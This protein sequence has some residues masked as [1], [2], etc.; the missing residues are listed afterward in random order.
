MSN[1]FTT[2][3]G[4]L[5]AV[6]FC[7]FSFTANA[8]TTLLTEDFETWPLTTQGWSFESLDPATGAS[9]TPLPGS[10]NFNATVS[11]TGT[12]SAHHDWWGGT[13]PFPAYNDWMVSPAIDLT[14]AVNP[15]MSFWQFTYW[16]ANYAFY[17][18][19]SVSTVD[20]AT[21][22][23]NWMSVWQD[24]STGSD[25]VWDS[26]SVD[27]TPFI[28][29][30]IWIGF[31]YQGQDGTEWFIDDVDVTDY[32]TQVF[33]CTDSTAVNYNPAATDDDGSCMWMGSD[34]STAFTA[35]DGVNTATGAPEWWLYTAPG[36]GILNVSSIGS[37]EDTQLGLF[38]NCFAFFGAYTDGDL[39][40]NDDYGSWLFGE[41]ESDLTINV[42][43]GM[44]I[45]IYWADGWATNGFDFN[46]TFTAA[47]LGCTDSTAVN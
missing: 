14:S 44:P 20:P 7:A 35:V 3:T 2:W 16:A 40:S 5:L 17:H 10:W 39:G 4:A 38:S 22:T 19:V 15:V 42:Y 12:Y 32:F 34:C 27:L 28:G 11:H 26:V 45:Y 31:N 8:Q 21:G 25:F 46:V 43:S 30:T 13:Q 29:Q 33:G 41:I 9:I 18:D 6:V 36:D 47:V 1:R 37:G 24:F 23:P